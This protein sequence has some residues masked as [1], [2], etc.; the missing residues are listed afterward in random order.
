MEKSSLEDALR[1]LTQAQATLVQT[2]AVAQ[3][4]IAESQRR[5]AGYERQTAD[6]FARNENTIKATVSEGFQ[7]AKFMLEHG[8][9]AIRCRVYSFSLENCRFA[10][11]SRNFFALQFRALNRPGSGSILRTCYLWAVH[12]RPACRGDAAKWAQR[13]WSPKETD[14]LEGRQMSPNDPR[15]PHPRG[16]AAAFAESNLPSVH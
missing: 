10:G 8:L 5:M 6:R 15:P 16:H 1:A 2:Q 3:S 12:E 4:Q 13:V 11:Q 7:S 9:T 14:M